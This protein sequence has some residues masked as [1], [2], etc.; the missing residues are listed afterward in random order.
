MLVGWMVGL[1]VDRS[2]G[3]DGCSAYYRIAVSVV[4]CCHPCWHALGRS[5]VLLS[6]VVLLGGVKLTH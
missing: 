4:G 6:L 3:L 2:V 1:L 5:H